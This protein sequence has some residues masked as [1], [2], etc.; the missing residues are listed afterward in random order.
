MHGCAVS[1]LFPAHYGTHQV[2]ATL[3]FSEY[4]LRERDRSCRALALAECHEEE[5]QNQPVLVWRFNWH[6]H[7]RSATL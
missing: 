6:L 4:R 5:V 1:A 3:H 7:A 2:A